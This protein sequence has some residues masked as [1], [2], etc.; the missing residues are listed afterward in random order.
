[1]EEAVEEGRGGRRC[2]KALEE[3]V[4]GRGSRW[5]KSLEGGVGGRCGGLDEGGWLTSCTYLRAYQIKLK[6]S[7]LI[8]KVYTA[9]SS[10]HV[11]NLKTVTKSNTKISS[12]RAMRRDSSKRYAE[13]YPSQYVS[14]E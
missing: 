9:N 14:I 3:G 11:K 13:S 7:K 4:G 12:E 10:K 5:K 1:V 8:M 6:L 2:R